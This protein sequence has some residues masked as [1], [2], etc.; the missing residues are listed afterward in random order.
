MLGKARGSVVGVGGGMRMGVGSGWSF[1][2]V[3]TLMK[4]LG[5]T[6]NENRLK[7]NCNNKMERVR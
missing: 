4:T 6:S 5:I 1:W 2:R 3:L 7:G